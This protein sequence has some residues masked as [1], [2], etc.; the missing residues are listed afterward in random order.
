MNTRRLS[1][2]HAAEL[3][4][5]RWN[6]E[7]AFRSLKQTMSHRKMLSTTASNAAVELDWTMIGFWLLALIAV[8]NVRG[9]N[10]NRI[11][12]AGSLRMVRNWVHHHTG[13]PP[14]GGL[15]RQLRTA[16]IDE[17]ERLNLK[18]SHDW[19]HKKRQ[20]PPGKPILRMPTESELAIIKELKDENRAA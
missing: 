1:N 5:L 12:I 8:D 17:Y 13:R 4:S 3:Y 18:A 9:E 19:P 20:K 15:L 2:N 10:K 14:A 16:L 11:S 6:V 7:V